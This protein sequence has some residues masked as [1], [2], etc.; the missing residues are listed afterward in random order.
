MYK[1][2]FTLIHI[3]FDSLLTTDTSKK[4]KYFFFHLVC[5]DSLSTDTIL[6]YE[7][8]YVNPTYSMVLNVFYYKSITEEIHMTPTKIISVQGTAYNADYIYWFEHI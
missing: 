1:R 8:S 5:Q 6:F 3:I 2:S 7:W 4:I